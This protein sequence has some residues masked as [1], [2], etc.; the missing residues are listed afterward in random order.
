V[1][2]A[3]AGGVD[4][5]VPPAGA[6]ANSF[7]AAVGAGEIGA[8]CWLVGFRPCDGSVDAGRGGGFAAAR[9]CSTRA[10]GVGVA[11]TEASFGAAITAERA[12]GAAVGVG[13]A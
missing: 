6:A 1:T 10:T 13:F 5:P 4:V 8:C 7:G 2:G 12:G 3:A 9:R 11:R